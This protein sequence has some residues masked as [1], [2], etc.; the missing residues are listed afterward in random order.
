MKL[1]TYALTLLLLAQTLL[2]QVSLPQLVLCIGDDGH[3]AFEEANTSGACFI[4]PPETK[5]LAYAPVRV[6]AVHPATDHCVDIFLDWHLSMAQYKHD[7][8]QVKKMPS[9]VLSQT[10]PVDYSTKLN[11]INNDEQSA[12]H[13][14][15]TLIARSI[16]LLI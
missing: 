15:G 4:H 13:T 12:I 1:K 5:P 8:K 11:I 6:Q 16:I 10:I 14:S 2:Y 7:S 3:V 9:L